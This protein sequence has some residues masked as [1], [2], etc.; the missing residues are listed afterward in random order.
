MK[1]KITT[2]FLALLFIV[3][4]VS[5]SIFMKRKEK[6][7]TDGL[8]TSQNS[9]MANQENSN[10]IEITEDTFDEEVLKSDKTVLIDFYATWCNPCRQLSPIIDKVS[11]ERQE[12]KFVR[13]DVDENN[14]LV[15]KYEIMYMPTLIVIKDGEE[16]DRSI[17]LINEEQIVELINK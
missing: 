1:K 17:G 6:D 9:K 11:L 7:I 10:V 3:L 16:V 5:V 14:E 13:I 12:V 15:G 4:L 8:Q 2:I